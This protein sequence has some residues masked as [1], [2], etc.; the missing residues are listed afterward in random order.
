MENRCYVTDLC[1]VTSWLRECYALI[2]LHNITPIFRYKFLQRHLVSGE[3]LDIYINFNQNTIHWFINNE[4]QENK[5]FKFEKNWKDYLTENDV[6]R[7]GYTSYSKGNEI[8][9]LEYNHQWFE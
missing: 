1:L 6:L 9:L 7:F 8:K 2:R 4:K 3:I 5:G